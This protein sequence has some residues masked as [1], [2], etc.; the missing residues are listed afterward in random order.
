M[1]DINS[2]QSLVSSVNGV[3]QKLETAR[4]SILFH[5][6]S[7]DATLSEFHTTFNKLMNKFSGFAEYRFELDQ[8]HQLLLNNIEMLKLKELQEKNERERLA[9]LDK[10]ETI[11]NSNNEIVDNLA[12]IDNNSSTNKS[13]SVPARSPTPTLAIIIPKCNKNIKKIVKNIPRKNAKPNKPKT[14]KTVKTAKKTAKTATKNVNVTVKKVA[15]VVHNDNKS[16]S[17]NKSYMDKPYE[18]NAETANWRFAGVAKSSTRIYVGNLP[19]TITREALEYFIR[20]RGNVN[21]SQIIETQVRDAQGGRSTYGLLRFR[22]DVTIKKISQFM[23]K[24]N[25][26][27]EEIY[28]KKQEEKDKK[29]SKKK[30]VV[31]WKKRVFLKF[32]QNFRVYAN[33]EAMY[34]DPYADRTLFIR[35]FDILNENCHCK[36][37]QKLL[38]YGGDLRRDIKVGVDS[39]GD[40]YCIATFKYIN[41]AIYCCNSEIEFNGRTLEMR[42]SRK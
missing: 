12:E 32:N 11:S 7:N 2:L 36:M 33:E 37:T 27:N 23:N 34:N 9:I 42:Y 14:V 3:Q 5:S 31:S 19:A 35:N 18:Y 28:K 13:Y 26:E 22:G 4:L 41:G 8:F 10:L 39:F 24:I 17:S 1:S 16:V 29:G 30:Q 6:G 15:D 40:P 20:Q 25:K 38:E 21:R